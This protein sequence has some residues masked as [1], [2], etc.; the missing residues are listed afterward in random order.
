M[1]EVSTDVECQKQTFS[2]IF[3]KIAKLDRGALRARMRVRT[4]PGPYNIT[5]NPPISV[6]AVI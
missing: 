5:A 3:G 2:T 6:A 4:S 1:C